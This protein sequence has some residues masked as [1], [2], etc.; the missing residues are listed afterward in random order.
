MKSCFAWGK[1]NFILLEIDWIR[2]TK[3]KE[4]RT[5]KIKK[6]WLVQ[7]CFVCKMDHKCHINGLYRLRLKWEIQEDAGKHMNH[8]MS[9]TTIFDGW[10]WHS[11]F[12]NRRTNMSKLIS[13][14][15]YT[16]HHT[17]AYIYGEVGKKKTFQYH[18]SLF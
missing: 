10:D 6:H 17:N 2:T 15:G 12:M 9:L 4:F 3:S 14:K 1:L 8:Y 7:F 16:L 5:W 13:W 11:W 18:S